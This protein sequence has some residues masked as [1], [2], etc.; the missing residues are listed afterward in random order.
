MTFALPARTAHRLRVLGG[1]IVLLVLATAPFERW[2]LTRRSNA[3]QERI[4]DVRRG[5]SARHPEGWQRDSVAVAEVA[6]LEYHR[7]HVRRRL[8][9]QLTMEGWTVRLLLAGGLLLLVGT[10]VRRRRTAD[11]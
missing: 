5:A 11:G 9:T 3:M 8:V 1:A 7:A 4:F 2:Y 6:E 10:V